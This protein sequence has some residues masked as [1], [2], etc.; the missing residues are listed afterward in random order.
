MAIIPVMRLQHFYYLNYRED[1]D[2]SILKNL[3]ATTI[4]LLLMERSYHIH[5]GGV[6]Q[7]RH[8]YLKVYSFSSATAIKKLWCKSNYSVINLNNGRK[9]L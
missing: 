3:A 7:L 6:L 2:A 1:Q 4:L 5:H 8:I 9:N